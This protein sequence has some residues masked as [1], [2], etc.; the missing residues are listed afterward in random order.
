MLDFQMERT[1]AA[2]EF[3]D[4]LVARGVAPARVLGIRPL[5]LAK[6]GR[7][8]EAREAFGFD[9]YFAGGETPLWPLRG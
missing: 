2:L 9:T 7:T 4:D 5:A 1:E 8:G 6:L 3:A